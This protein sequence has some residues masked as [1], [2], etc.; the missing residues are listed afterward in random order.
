VDQPSLPLL[1]G[2]FATSPAA[3]R[4]VRPLA[5]GAR[6]A[7]LLEEGPAGFTLVDGAPRLAPGPLGDPDF[8][9]RLPR[10]AVER[11]AAHPAADVGEV[12]LAFFHLVLE[13]DPALRVGI[14]VQASMARLVSHGYL[15]VL[16]LGG[17][18]VALWLLKRG[19]A[20][21]ARVIDRL[22]GR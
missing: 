10:G 2:Y 13:R 8:T 18:K 7:L 5:A 14:S 9:L 4:A 11:L 17:T 16:A 22:R 1:A 12:G 15:A 21:P 20:S 3:R 19:L 6:V